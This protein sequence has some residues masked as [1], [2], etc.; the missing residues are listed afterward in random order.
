MLEAFLICIGLYIIWSVFLWPA[1][2]DFSQEKK[3]NYRQYTSRLAKAQAR[4][5]N[6]GSEWHNDPDI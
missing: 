6:D 2:H 5:K 4:S 1:I 3:D